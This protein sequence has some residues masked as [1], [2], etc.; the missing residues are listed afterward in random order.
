V[1]NDMT[2]KFRIFCRASGVW[3][4]E[5][6]QS[7][8]QTSLRT[9]DESEA[10]RLLQA[11][12]EA[13]RQPAI[14]VQI[15]RAYLNPKLVTRT[16]HEVMESLVSF[17]HGSNR[18]RWDRAIEDESFESILQLPLIET[19]AEHFLKV[20]KSGKVSSNVYLRRIHNYALAM[21]WLLKPVIPR[22]VWPK[23][24]YKAQASLPE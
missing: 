13:H 8:Y 5:D 18:L 4:I 10:N 21:H 20:L 16:W 3:Y 22:A 24:S 2:D 12:N 23:V 6:K 1:S 15:A 11:R 14:N 17:K 9:R 7:K 19:R